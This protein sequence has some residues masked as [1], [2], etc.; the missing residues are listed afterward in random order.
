MASEA[1]RPRPGPPTGLT[2]RRFAPNLIK[3]LN[4]PILAMGKE[5]I[6]GIVETVMGPRSKHDKGL[7]YTYEAWVDILGG[8]GTA[9]VFDHYFS[10][11][12]CGLIEYLD[13]K[14][15]LTDD[16]R[17]YGVYRGRKTRL[18]KE[19]CSDENGSWVKRPELCHALEEHFRRTQEE[20]Y[21]GHVE[22]GPCAFED[23][24]R[25]GLGPLW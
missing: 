20:A 22:K 18:L 21:R 24:S 25:N 3:G 12:L 14:G 1:F 4:D 8:R 5:M 17:M 11:I 10:N 23:R 16:V 6:M 7:P 15:F 9:P 13:D 19:L 2:I